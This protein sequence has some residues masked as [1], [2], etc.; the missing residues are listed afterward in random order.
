M[1]VAMNAAATI[2]LARG[3]PSLDIVDVEG[4]R[5][6]AAR[7][8]TNDPGGVTAYG[9]SVGY[10]PLRTLI[11]G[12]HGVDEKQVLV[13][14]GSLQADAFLFDELVGEGVDVVVERPSYDRTLL[15]L[16]ERGARLHSVPLEADGLDVDAL[17]DL[18]ERGVRPALAHLIPNFHNPAGYTLA[19]AKRERI[20]ALAREHSMIVFEDDPYVSLR[21]RGASLPTML[22]LDAGGESVVYA[23]S[24]SKTVCPGIRVGY[25]VGP[26]ALIAKIAR[27]ATN[28]YISPSMVSAGIVYEFCVSGALERS[29]DAVRTALEA[30]SGALARAL[31]RELPEVSFVEPDGGYFLWVGLPDGVDSTA[32][33]KAAAEHGVAV[34]D[35]DDFV[36]EGRAGALRL[37][38]A[39]VTVAEIDEA[40]ARLAVAYATLT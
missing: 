7:A 36:A 40:I 39:P 16:R 23:S 27:R 8:F 5:E 22:S 35:G 31:E 4:L 34:V 21:F 32:L 30:R 19:A 2:S 38:F 10:L 6:A 17:A 14:N 26:E 33:T 15:G 9:T 12:W 20:V 25:I 11:A 1:P 28:T 37:S 24:F 18:F 13:T 3:A 29:I